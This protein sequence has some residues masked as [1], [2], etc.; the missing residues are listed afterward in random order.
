MRNLVSAGVVYL[1][2]NQSVGRFCVEAWLCYAFIRTH[3]WLPTYLIMSTSVYE[4]DYWKMFDFKIPTRRNLSGIEKV[5]KS[6]F[7]PVD[8]A[9]THKFIEEQLEIDY[10]TACIKWNIDLRTET[11]LDPEGNYIWERVSPVRINTMRKRRIEDVK[12]NNSDLYFLPIEPPQRQEKTVSRSP[13]QR[14]I[15]GKEPLLVW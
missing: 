13:K 9:D 4:P 15:T 14:V 5:K 2:F 8:P 7:G 10:K 3:C 12:E 6:L 11:T 1:R